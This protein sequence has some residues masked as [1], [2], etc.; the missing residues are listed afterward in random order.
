MMIKTNNK[1]KYLS[2]SILLM[3]YT[4]FNNINITLAVTADDK[5]A[6]IN[7]FSD[8]IKDSNT[9]ITYVG[10]GLLVISAIVATLGGI[11]GAK[12]IS[13]GL[14]IGNSSQVKKDAENLVKILIHTA[15]VFAFSGILAIIVGYLELF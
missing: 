1:F 4:L 2:I 15:I 5:K 9:L 12:R 11:M 8:P 14:M 10:V 7:R 13:H 6:A 3:L